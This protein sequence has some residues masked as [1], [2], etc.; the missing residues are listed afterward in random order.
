V[1]EAE[2]E[3]LSVREC[4]CLREGL[5]VRERDRDSERE[6]DIHISAYSY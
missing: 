2:R 4:V 5:S 6:S 1:R 3:R